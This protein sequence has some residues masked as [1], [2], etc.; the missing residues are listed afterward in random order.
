MTSPVY[1]SLHSDFEAARSLF[2]SGQYEEAAQLFA[3][4][5][6]EPLEPTAPDFKKRRE[7][8]EAA[9]P[10]YA[11]CLVALGR[12][13]EADR[14]ILEQLRDDPFYEPAPGQFAQPVMFRYIAVREEHLTELDALKQRVLRTRQESLLKEE[15]QRELDEGR[16]AKLEELAGTETVVEARS[17]LVAT[18]PFGIGQLQNGSSGLGA[19]FAA[20]E[21]VGVAATIASA[22]VAHDFA[23]VDCRE[24]TDVDCVELERRFDTARAVN[25]ASF[26]VTGALIVAGVAEA[27]VSFV[28]A[29]TTRKRRAIP[30]RVTLEPAVV[31]AE[32]GAL[33]G[34]TARFF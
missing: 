30:P 32:E 24:H 6:D 15:R 1:A 2:T 31:F 10:V 12:S 34:V 17:R 8:L 16:L 29:T 5:L 11:A 14:V 25:W 7:I 13:S 28:P 22:F 26:A 4:V 3:R 21:V 27:H 9:R 19:F 18:V 33:V 20:S 23:S